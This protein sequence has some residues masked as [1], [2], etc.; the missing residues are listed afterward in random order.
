MTQSMWFLILAGLAVLLITLFILW[1]SG[2]TLNAAYQ[3]P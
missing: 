1:T 2:G 3:Y